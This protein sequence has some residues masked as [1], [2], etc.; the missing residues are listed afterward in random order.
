[1]II[2]KDNKRPLVQFLKITSYGKTGGKYHRENINEPQKKEEK[3]TWQSSERQ[4]KD[5]MRER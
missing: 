1:M 5:K 2:T 3:K 4:T